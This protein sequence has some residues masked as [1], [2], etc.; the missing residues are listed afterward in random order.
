WCRTPVL[1]GQVG[2]TGRAA[3]AAAG[4]FDGGYDQLQSLEIVAVELLVAGDQ[5]VALQQRV[6][7]DQEIGDRAAVLAGALAMAALHLAGT[8][9]RLGLDGAEA[10]AHL[11]EDGHGFGAVLERAA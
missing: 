1:R 7:P 11:L 5:A 3:A 10:D 4:S 9:R 8:Q 2:V 6:G